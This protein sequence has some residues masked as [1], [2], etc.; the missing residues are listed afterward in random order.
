MTPKQICSITVSITPP[1]NISTPINEPKNVETT[2][3]PKVITSPENDEWEKLENR[4]IVD[5]THVFKSLQAICHINFDCAFRDL[6]FL[7]E[8][9]KGYLSIF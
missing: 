4:R 2:Y 3:T 1:K 8:I 7:N 9:R 6:E 5:V